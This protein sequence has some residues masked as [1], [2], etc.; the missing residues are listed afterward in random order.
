[1]DDVSAG[2]DPATD[3]RADRLGTGPPGS[4]PVDG[5]HSL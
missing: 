4:G 2:S 1:M 5:L 3:M